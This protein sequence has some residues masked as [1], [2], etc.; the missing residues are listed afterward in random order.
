MYPGACSCLHQ[1]DKSTGP[2]GRFT[3]EKNLYQTDV[4]R[5]FTQD[6]LFLILSQFLSAA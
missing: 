2:T 6:V 4:D 3:Q 5:K 1:Y